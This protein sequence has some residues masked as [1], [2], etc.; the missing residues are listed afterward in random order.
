MGNSKLQKLEIKRENIGDILTIVIPCKNEGEQ[1]L[2]T[3]GLIDPNIKIIVADISTDNTIE[4]LKFAFPL[5]KIKIAEGGL[6]AVGRNEGSKFVK[7][8]YV[9]FLDA[10]V[11][12]FDND[13]IQNCINKMEDKNLDL[14]TVRFTVNDSMVYK[15]VYLI[16]DFI[17]L[18]TSFSTPFAVGGFM[19]F[20]T[21]KF[22]QLGG[23]D[24]E[25]KFAEDYHLSSKIH[26]KQFHILNKKVVTTSRRFRNKGVFYM[27]KMMTKCWL[28]RNDDS[29][30]KKDYG[31]W[32]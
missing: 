26:P 29:F 1:L 5:R 28:N 12:I 25:D 11:M 18:F 16:F 23:F 22:K 2:K 6:P 19:L 10:D 15:I 31:Y 17:Q 14:L 32:D 21:D 7:T 30:Y 27:I 20:R 9:L 24:P 8:K 3:I 13:L 4:L